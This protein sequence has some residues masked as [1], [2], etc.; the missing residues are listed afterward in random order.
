MNPVSSSGP[1]NIGVPQPSGLRM[2]PVSSSGPANSRHL[3]IDSSV[4]TSDPALAIVAS[5]GGGVPAGG[6]YYTEACTA[7]RRTLQC[8]PSGPRAS[9]QDKGCAQIVNA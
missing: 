5:S 8:D 3:P 7:F 6:D 9:L 1:A 2:N 4:F